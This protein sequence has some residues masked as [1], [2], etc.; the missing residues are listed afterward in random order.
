VRFWDTSGLVPLFVTEATTARAEQLYEDDSEIAVWTLTRVELLSAFSR[1]AR[2]GAADR[3]SLERA[4]KEVIAASSRWI[5]VSQVSQVREHAERMVLN[6]PLRAAD[7]LQL[8]AA[9][10]AADSD[11]ASLHFVT[12]DRRLGEAARREGFSVLGASA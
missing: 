1:R 7:A 2:E 11:P 4:Q 9:L 8:G 10:V 6:Y 5:E 12:F 3:G